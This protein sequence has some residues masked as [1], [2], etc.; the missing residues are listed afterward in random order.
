M[1]KTEQKK[2][3][4]VGWTDEQ[5]AQ[6]YEEHDPEDYIGQGEAIHL[7][8]ERAQW[9]VISFKIREDDLK[10]LKRIAEAEA[11]G[12]TTLLRRWVKEKLAA[13]FYFPLMIATVRR[14]AEQTK[15]LPRIKSI[16]HALQPDRES[17]KLLIQFEGL[18]KPIEY[19]MHPS[20]I[21]SLEI[22]PKPIINL[23][24]EDLLQAIEEARVR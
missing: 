7:E 14:V 11:I 4:M 2:P 13:R 10:R 8:P 21:E 23:I 16:S 22:N 12:Y 20:E 5:I 15:E 19:P 9:K 1:K 18:A 3:L 24:R 17:I 6:W